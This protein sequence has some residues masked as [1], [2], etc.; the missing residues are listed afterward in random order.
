[1][2]SVSALYSD[3]Q[4]DHHCFD[5]SWT[6]HFGH[7]KVV[8]LCPAFTSVKTVCRLFKLSNQR[9]SLVLNG[10]LPESNDFSRERAQPGSSRSTNPAVP[11]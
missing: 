8:S 5:P 10:Q 3:Y 4:N 1:M 11:A 6:D 9:D 7:A 2:L